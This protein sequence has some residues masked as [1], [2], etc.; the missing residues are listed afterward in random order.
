MPKENWLQNNKDCNRDPSNLSGNLGDLCLGKLGFKWDLLHPYQLTWEHTWCI[1]FAF[2]IQFLFPK[3]KKKKLLGCINGNREAQGRFLKRLEL[4]LEAKSNLV[5][6]LVH[7][8]V[9]TK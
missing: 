2:A 5:H 3:I 7:L 6:H 1:P 4:E 8:L 9:P